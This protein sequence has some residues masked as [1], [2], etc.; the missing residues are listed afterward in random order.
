MERYVL[1]MKEM[2]LVEQLN[3][4][5]VER[6]N[7]R[8]EKSGMEDELAVMMQDMRT[9]KDIELQAQQEKLMIQSALR[10]IQRQKLSALEFDKKRE[11]ERLAIEREKIM[12]QE[13]GLNEEIR[14][15]NNSVMD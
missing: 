8:K 14:N 1:R 9:E 4:M 3:Q 6:E 13:I 5:K 11:L 12:N 10:A 15:L 7:I 2:E